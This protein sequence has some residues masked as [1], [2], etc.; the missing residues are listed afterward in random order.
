VGI[1]AAAVLIAFAVSR[2]GA[3]AEP[4]A[5]VEPATTPVATAAI[6]PSVVEPTIAETTE[7]AQP[8]AIES[9]EPPAS[10]KPPALTA[11]VARPTSKPPPPGSDKGSTSKPPSGTITD[12]GGRR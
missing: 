4:S 3:Q 5:D 7:P 11:P 2:T 1:L 8:P 9:A 10:A 12:F 6:E